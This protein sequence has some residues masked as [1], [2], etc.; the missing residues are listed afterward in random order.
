MYAPE[1]ARTQ[2]EHVAGNAFYDQ[3]H[4]NTLFCRLQK[5]YSITV[6]LQFICVV[7]KRMISFK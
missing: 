7:K 6:I 3:L 5:Y 1:V 2:F 4:R